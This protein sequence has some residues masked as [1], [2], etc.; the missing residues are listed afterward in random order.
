M[1][2]R[3]P[4]KNGEAT[5]KEILKVAIEVFSRRGYRKASIR[6]IADAVPITQAGLLYH[7][8]TKESLFVEV[9][10]VRDELDMAMSDDIAEAFRIGVGHNAQVPAL[11]HLFATVSA[12]ATDPSHPGHCFFQE[13]YASLIGMLEERIREGQATGEMSAQVKPEEA[14]RM[15]IALL[16]GI[17]MQWLFEPEN[18]DMVGIFNA[19]WNALLG[20]AVDTRP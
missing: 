9:L 7:F 13:R 20:V 5:K 19:F 16:D 12:E 6:E 3:A 8:K 15:T 10:R 18:V 1:A 11:V 4:Y 17:Q 14:A 2:A